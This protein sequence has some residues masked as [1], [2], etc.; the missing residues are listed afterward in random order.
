MITS[1]FKL[2][3]VTNRKLCRED[4]L[5]RMERVAASGVDG[6][7]L[8]EK[9]LSAEGYGL[10]ANQVT[11]ICRKHGTFCFLHTYARKALDLGIKSIHLPLTVLKGLD[12]ESRSAF[13]QLGASCHSLEDVREAEQLGC[14]YVTLG[15]IFATDCKPGLPP[16]GLE[17][18]RTVCSAASIPVYAIGG[19][20]PENAAACREAGA[21]GVCVMSGLMRCDDPAEYVNRFRAAFQ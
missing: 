13:Q 18:L 17:L 14:T 11:E 16:R 12:E 5:T 20:S 8:R 10:L 15:H 3:S 9:D 6:V 2:I 19:I 7:I 1:M 21:A 4:F